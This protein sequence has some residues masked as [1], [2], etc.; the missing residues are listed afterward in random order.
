MQINCLSHID[1]MTFYLYLLICNSVSLIPN[2]TIYFSI[3]YLNFLLSYQSGLFFNLEK[4]FNNFL[5]IV[6]AII[7]LD[8]D[9]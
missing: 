7:I 1:L 8:A 9:D 3:F 6:N 5:L 2:F 4:F